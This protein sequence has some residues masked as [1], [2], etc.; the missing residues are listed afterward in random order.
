MLTFRVEDMTCGHCAGKITRA[1]ASV[2]GGAQ[3]EVNI[4][5]K[6][7]RVSSAAPESGLVAAMAQAGYTARRVEEVAAADPQ[8]A[9]GGCCCAPR[10][11]AVR[12]AA[13]RTSCCGG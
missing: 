1:I 3:V 11:P 4:P 12:E 2:D 7:V 6:L 5:Q 10:T 9:A 8:P 13:P